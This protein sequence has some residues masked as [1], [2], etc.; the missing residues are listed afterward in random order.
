MWQWAITTLFLSGKL[1]K[2]HLVKHTEFEIRIGF[3]WP[4]QED[5]CRA[6]H[7]KH[8]HVQVEAEKKHDLGTKNG[9]DISRKKEATGLF[10][11]NDGLYKNS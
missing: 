9:L 10:D 4:D 8:H 1:S 11:K 5:S 3:P 7:L 2:G 6:R